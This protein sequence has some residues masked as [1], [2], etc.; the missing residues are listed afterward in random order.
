MGRETFRMNFEKLLR[1]V[2]TTLPPVL[3]TYTFR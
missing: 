3:A 1:L 2:Y